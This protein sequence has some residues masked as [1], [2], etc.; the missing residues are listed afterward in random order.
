MM[1]WTGS[2]GTELTS[3]H[4]SFG[5]DKIPCFNWKLF[6]EDDRQKPQKI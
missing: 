1:S 4:V 2:V 3:K 5:S 6:L